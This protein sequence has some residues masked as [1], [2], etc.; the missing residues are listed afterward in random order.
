MEQANFGG[1]SPEVAGRARGLAIIHCFVSSQSASKA[2]TAAVCVVVVVV[3]V[4]SSTQSWFSVNPEK[5]ARARGGLEPRAGW[6]IPGCCLHGPSGCLEHTLG[7][8]SD[9]IAFVWEEMKCFS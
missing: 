5:A 4:A 3:K 7:V 6:R 9:V 8:T 2:V 1:C